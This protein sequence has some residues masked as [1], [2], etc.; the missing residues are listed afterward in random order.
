MVG[1]V[2]EGEE[3]LDKKVCSLRGSGPQAPKFRRMGWVGPKGSPAVTLHSLG[4][5]SSPW[6]G[7][8]R[9]LDLIPQHLLLPCS[10]LL[11]LTFLS[12]ILRK[13]RY[14]FHLLFMVCLLCQDVSSLGAGAFT[15]FMEV[16]QYRQAS[17]R[18]RCSIYV[19]GMKKQVNE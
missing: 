1:T 18:S 11:W 17:A 2:R 13:L 8:F 19:Q 9:T 16:S 3:G 14:L 5:L 15:L 6:W 12:N 10:H 7:P 4:P